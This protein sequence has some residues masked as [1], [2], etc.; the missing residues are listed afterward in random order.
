ME[1]YFWM[2]VL[3][4]RRC[5]RCISH[6]GSLDDVSELINDK[7]AITKKQAKALGEFFHVSAELF[8]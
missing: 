7:Q 2:K 6:N 1:K 8:M 5:R 4:S 3:C